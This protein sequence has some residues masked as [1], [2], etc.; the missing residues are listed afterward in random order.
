MDRNAGSSL[1]I[2]VPTSISLVENAPY[3]PFADFRTSKKSVSNSGFC[4]MAGGVEKRELKVE[5]EEDGPWAG[6][7]ADV[8]FFGGMIEAI[9]SNGGLNGLSMDGAC[10]GSRLN[11]FQASPGRD[12]GMPIGFPVYLNY[13]FVNTNSSLSDKNTNPIELESPSSHPFIKVGC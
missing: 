10:L 6:E 4:L 13:S 2:T 12:S 9:N 7:N 3:P 5:P 8:R 1:Q 11:D